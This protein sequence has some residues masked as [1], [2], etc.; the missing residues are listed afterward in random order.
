[1]IAVAVT[2]AEVAERLAAMGDEVRAA[3]AEATQALADQLTAAAMARLPAGPLA[4]SIEATV[5]PGADAA[6]ATVGSALPYAGVID[7]GFAGVEQVRE[8]LRLQSVAFGKP[9]MPRQVVVRAHARQVAIPAREFL[10]EPL[11]EMADEI[12]ESYADV[13]RAALAQ[14][15]ES[16]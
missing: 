16:R 9:M 1:V 12:A 2:G 5:E 6:R 10:E 15:D 13:V 11:D 4:D 8:S 7:H 3:L 14:L